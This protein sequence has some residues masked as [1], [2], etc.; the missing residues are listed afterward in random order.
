MGKA[1]GCDIQ[2][3]DLTSAN[4]PKIFFSLGYVPSGKHHKLLVVKFR[5][6]S[7]KILNKWIGLQ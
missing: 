6:L 7:V 4:G 5:F 1:K 2:I 3:P